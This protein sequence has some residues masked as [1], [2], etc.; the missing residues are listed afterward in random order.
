M[1]GQPQSR[2][3]SN[4]NPE[5]RT[6]PDAIAAEFTPGSGYSQ[7]GAF[8]FAILGG[9]PLMSGLHQARGLPKT[10]LISQLF[11]GV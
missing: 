2:R 8:W 1:Q 5:I 10:L 7:N 9:N 3:L 6:G 4:P 11:V